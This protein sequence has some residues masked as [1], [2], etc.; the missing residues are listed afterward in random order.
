M[1]GELSPA[2]R[3]SAP[4]ALEA[5]KG[6]LDWFDTPAFITDRCNRFVHANQR[7]IEMV[8]DPVAVPASSPARFIVGAMLGPFRDRF[9]E[10]RTEVGRCIAGLKEEVRAGRLAQETLSLLSRSLT[11]DDRVRPIDQAWE[12]TVIVR[13]VA[14]SMMQVKEHVIPLA[15]GRHNISVWAPAEQTSAFGERATIVA[16]LTSRQLQVARLYATG[17]SNRSVAAELGI[18]WR[19]VRGHVEDVYARLDLHSR[20]ELTRMFVRSGL[21]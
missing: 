1:S 16:A 12:G 4:S 19:T 14:G 13:P 15:D 21:A 17:H 10:R 7:F 11:F 5:A 3:A 2:P 9:P 8:G 6:A 20:A 18:G